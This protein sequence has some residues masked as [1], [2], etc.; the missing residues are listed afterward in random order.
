MIIQKRKK[1]IFI[2]IIFLLIGIITGLAI[3]IRFDVEKELPAKDR[4]IS[5][6]SKS[7]LSKLNTSLAEVAEIVKP[8]VVNISTTKIF[9]LREHPLRDFFDDPFL[10][11][12]FGD[13]FFFGPE[14][15][16]KS[17][18]LGSGVIVSEDGY[19]LT[20]NHVIKDADK[21]RV[22]LI[23]KREFDG[24]VIGIDPRTDLAVIK[25]DAKGLPAIKIGDSDNLKVGELVM[26]IGNPFGLSHTITMGIVSAV[27]RSNVGIADYEDF[28]QTDAA[29]NPGN[30]G[31]ALV[32]IKGELIGI[33][34]AIF[35]TSGGYMGIG[36]AIPSNMAKVVMESII[37]H[38]KVIRGWLGV[39]IQDITPE[40]A[41]HFN[42]TQ[43]EGAIVTDVV[44][45]SPAEKAGIR[46]GDIIIEFNGKHVKDSL[47]LRNI[48]S[49]TPP[50]KKLKVKVLRNGKEKILNV[51]IGEFS[52]KIAAI[53][54]GYNNVL[55]GVHVQELTDQLRESFEIPYK[56]KGVVVTEVEPN[57]PASG[58]LK[59][60]DVI[61]EID[62]KSIKSIEDYEN[63]VSKIKSVKSVLLLIYRLGNYLYVILK[64]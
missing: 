32:N 49:N 24:K 20:N 33:N 7:F 27:G 25:I 2:A 43:Q 26:A 48:V 39:T 62:R 54:G 38:G 8:S 60:G 28:I 56:V 18:A 55:K 52:D 41:K 36:F 16:Y 47:N 23:D 30:S 37:K 12:F 51:V 21:I 6:Y 42:V 50:G 10:R 13:H 58:I 53:K 3:S 17:T 19:I 46:R 34:T 5:S 31:G 63:V 64:P 44:E 14:R 9:T 45:D 22:R 1:L 40:I 11:R 35:S 59:R 4:E 57:S 29:I 61:Q 15:E